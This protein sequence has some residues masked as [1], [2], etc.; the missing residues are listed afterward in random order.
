MKITIDQKE[1]KNRLRVI[2]GLN[3]DKGMAVL[4]HFILSSNARNESMATDL[5]TSVREGFEAV[6]VDEN[7]TIGISRK[8]LFEIVNQLEDSVTL[9]SADNNIL[10]SGQGRAG[11]NLPASVLMTIRLFLK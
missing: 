7:G 2:Q 11:S 5:T 10:L 8:K 4:D 3:S 6:I 1:L 9:E